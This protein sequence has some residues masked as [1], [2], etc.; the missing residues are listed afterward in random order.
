MNIEKGK[1]Y[2]KIHIYIYKLLYKF[3][4]HNLR[5]ELRW[6]ESFLDQYWIWNSYLESVMYINKIEIK[7]FVFHCR[8]ILF[9]NK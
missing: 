4:L 9:L 1:K 5:W 6:H 3:Y 2:I 7:T 8:R